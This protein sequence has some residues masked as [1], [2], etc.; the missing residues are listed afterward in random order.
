MAAVAIGAGA[1]TAD[2]SPAKTLVTFP[3]IARAFAYD[4]GRVAWIDSAW[5]LRIRTVRTGAE[6]K[7]L[8]TNPYEEIPDFPAEITPFLAAN[9]RLVLERRRLVWRST[10]GRSLA[11]AA[12]HVYIGTVD[13]GRGRRVATE[14]HTDGWVGGYVTGIAGDGSGFSYGVV[15]VEQVAPE[16]D[17][18]HV[19][20]GSLWLIVDGRLRRVPDTPPAIVFARAAGRV[21]IAPVDLNERSGGD[22]VPAGTVEIRNATT[23]ALISTF[24]VGRVRA[25]ALSREIAAV[26]VGRRIKRYDV[27]SGQLLGLTVVPADT[28]FDLDMAADRIVFRPKSAINV[29][30][31][32]TGRI[33]TAAT[34]TPWRPSGVAVD[35]RTVSWAESR[36]IAPGEVS[37]KTFRTRI[38]TAALP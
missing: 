10:R 2:P 25:V 21:A 35:G 14:V 20:G 9:R 31:A 1:A 8:Y 23:G 18:T 4:A 16:S 33:S 17:R 11:E 30:D 27:V 28:A 6:R 26:L 15:T 29:L 22:P 32:S 38:R 3:G 13:A 37:K 24:S 19:V 7:I 34:T 36:R 5:A 12:D